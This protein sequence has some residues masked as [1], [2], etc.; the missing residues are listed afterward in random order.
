MYV[1]PIQRAVHTQTHRLEHTH[2]HAHARD[3]TH[4]HVHTY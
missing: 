1:Y 2:I 4:T 3:H